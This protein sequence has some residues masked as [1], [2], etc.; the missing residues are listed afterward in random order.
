[1]QQTYAASG[2]RRATPKVA[3]HR[4]Y[5]S[6][7]APPHAYAP[8]GHSV[9]AARQPAP[10][11]TNLVAQAWKL[12]QSSCQAAPLKGNAAS[13]GRPPVASAPGV[14]AGTASTTNAFGL[15]TLLGR[16]TPS[17]VAATSPGA[18]GQTSSL[19]SSAQSPAGQTQTEAAPG[20]PEVL[21]PPSDAEEPAAVLPA[22][23]I[24]IHRMSTSMLAFF[25]LPPRLQVSAIM[26]PV[27]DGIVDKVRWASF[28]AEVNDVLSFSSEKAH[29]HPTARSFA[30]LFVPFIVISF[31]VTAI[32][33][34]ASECSNFF[35]SMILVLLSF[36]GPPA[37]LGFGRW[38]L[39]LQ[40]SSMDE[41]TVRYVE[42]ACK[43]VTR[44][45]PGISFNLR[46]GTSLEGPAYY[47]EVA[48]AGREGAVAAVPAK[49]PGEASMAALGAPPVAAP[50]TPLA[51]AH[52]TTPAAS[53]LASRS[54]TPAATPTSQSPA[55]M[56]SVGFGHI[57][58]ASEP[59]RYS[60][61]HAG[62]QSRRC[63][64]CGNMHAA[65]TFCPKCGR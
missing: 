32:Q 5:A 39:T 13:P 11:S 63:T 19:R 24:D 4:G 65:G 36:G 21:A 62:I 56:G 2:S 27:L 15:G 40:M 9:G 30:F 31:C 52:A 14:A 60:S 25:E 3:R 48:V 51:A 33:L 64:H 47:V 6:G 29:L 43:V 55:K 42:Q 1:M 38:L 16:G 28:V 12:T 17:T 34:V 7:P 26:P 59:L 45:V 50:G 23:R 54:G 10:A 22:N 8:P 37:L 20:A 61:G 49:P 53:A 58:S 18:V 35:T 44:D 46:M 41:L 57:P